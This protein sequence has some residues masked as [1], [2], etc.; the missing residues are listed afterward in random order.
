MK[1]LILAVFCMAASIA[2]SQDDGDS[3]AEDIDSV[4]LRVSVLENIDVTAEKAP[5][6]EADELDEDIEAILE[7]AESLEG[8]RSPE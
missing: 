4:E 8:D 5:S 2:W 1:K 3:D 6:V 7:E